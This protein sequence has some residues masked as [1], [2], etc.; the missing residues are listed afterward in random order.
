LRPSGAANATGRR[1]PGDGGPSRAAF[2]SCE[3]TP[4]DIVG[5][6]CNTRDE[7]IVQTRKQCRLGVDIVKIADSYWGDMQ[8]VADEEI[9]A[10]V[11]EAHRHNLKVAGRSRA[12]AATQ[13]A[14]KAGVDLIYHALTHINRH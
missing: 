14:A 7:F 6:F 13:A 4:D 8:S 1:S 3:G 11:D 10:V 9:K 2:P 12:S 5:I